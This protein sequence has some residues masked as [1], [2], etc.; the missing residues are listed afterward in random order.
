MISPDNT[1]AMCMRIESDRPKSGGWIHRLS[2]SPAPARKRE[3]HEEPPK[4]SDAD[5]HRK[6]DPL[7]NAWVSKGMPRLRT[8]AAELG[9]SLASLARLQIGWEGEAWTNPEKNHL[10]QIVGIKRRFPTVKLYYLGSRPGLTYCDNWRGDGH[11]P[12]FVVEGASDVA[13]GLTMGLTVVGRPSN[14]GGISYLSRLLRAVGNR[15]IIVVAERDRKAHDEL[16]EIVRKKHNPECKG[17]RLCWP[18]LAGARESAAKL[19]NLLGRSVLYRLPPDKAKD[20]REW[21]NHRKADV[22]DFELMK[23][24]GKNFTLKMLRKARSK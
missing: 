6:L 10:C 14:T 20:M 5:L 13:A 8:L 9:V 17:C 18:G 23:R 19:S 15:Q 21:L 12:I 4:T 24:I 1:A 16:K 2:D 3:R 7:V 22:A 11:G